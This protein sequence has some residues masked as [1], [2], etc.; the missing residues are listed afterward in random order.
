MN[1]KTQALDP[2]VNVQLDMSYMMMARPVWV[3]A[4][5]NVFN[6]QSSP[7]LHVNICHIIYSKLHIIQTV[8]SQLAFCNYDIVLIE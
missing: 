7:S 1:V 6:N 4:V 2:C 5:V 8:A 3:S